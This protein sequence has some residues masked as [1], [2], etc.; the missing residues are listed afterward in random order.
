[1][2]WLKG[3]LGWIIG[4]FCVVILAAIVYAPYLPR[5]VQE[6]Y[7]S[8]TWPA[9]GQF[10]SVSGTIAEAQRD[11][12]FEDGV[13]GGWT[14]Y[15]PLSSIGEPGLLPIPSPTLNEW[16]QKLFEDKQ[17]KALLV[18]YKGKLVVE[19]YA[20]GFDTG[21]RFNSYSMVKSLVGALMLKAL[22]EHKIPSL[23]VPIK[24]YLPAIKNKTLAQTPLRDFLGMRSGISFEP[25]GV[26]AVFGGE[27]K[28][29]NKSIINPFG[30][31]VRLHMNGLDDVMSGLKAEQQRQGRYD[32]QNVNTALLGRVL[33]KVYN[34]PLE[35]I[36]A[37]KIWQ[38]SG[39]KNNTILAGIKTAFWRK[40]NASEDVSAYCCLYARA[41]DWVQVGRYIMTNGKESGKPFLPEKLWQLYMGM[42]IPEHSFNGKTK[43][44]AHIYH[45]I[46]DR[47]G[48]SLH[49]KFAYMFGSRGQTVYMMPQKDLVVVRF[50]EKIQLLHS[51]LYAAWQMLKS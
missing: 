7:P 24:N 33:A 1:M 17:G 34:M 49:G 22:A 51:T 48:Q 32:Y 18:Y 15:A 31:M 40:Y 36:L 44:G 38:P 3:K 12:T 45:N 21:S 43:Y 39:V 27:T 26:K 5:L 42:K 30:P 9:A 47:E 10:S 35:Q 41:R 14:Q 16:S 37:E 20:K 23:S 11:E 28:N 13:G 46:L 6:G 25:H 19:H 2:A 8:L 50:G 29:I 4:L